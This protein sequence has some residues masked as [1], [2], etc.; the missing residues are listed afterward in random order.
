MTNWKT[1]LCGCLAAIMIAIAPILQSG[2]VDWKA[3][4]IAA[5][6]AAFGFLAKDFNVTGGDVKSKLTLKS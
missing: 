3:L 4:V 5:L 6:V 1:T 2:T